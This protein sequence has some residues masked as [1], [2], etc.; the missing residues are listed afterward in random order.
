MS[1]FDVIIGYNSIKQELLMC[2]DSMKNIEKYKKLGV[3]P[4]R[5]IMLCGEPGV[6]KTLMAECFLKEC[7]CNTY[8]IRK[9][10][11]KDELIKQILYIFREAKKNAPS[12]IMLDDM[13]KFTDSESDH[14]CSQEYAAIQAGFEAC[15]NENVMV[16]AT[17]NQDFGIPRSLKRQGRFDRKIEMEFPSGDDAKLILEFFLSKKKVSKDVDLDKLSFLLSGC[18]CASLEMI[19]NDAG[20]YAA[21]EGK[22]VIEDSDLENACIRYLTSETCEAEPCTGEK[23]KV[24]AIHEAG[25]AVVSEFWRP[26]SVKAVS[27][28]GGSFYGGGTTATDRQ[29]CTLTENDVIAD[30]SVKLGGKAASSV[31]LDIVDVG[32]HTDVRRAYDIADTFVS[33]ICGD[34]F[35]SFDFRHDN[36]SNY[37]LDNRDQHIE[38]LLDEVY[39]V[40]LDIIR[41]NAKLVKVIADKLVKKNVLTYKELEQVIDKVGWN[42]SKR[43]P[44]QMPQPNLHASKSHKR[45][46]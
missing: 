12:V 39:D 21:Y 26:N 8:T 14:G 16:I 1:A 46:G 27:I 33:G 28:K 22:D 5:G 13:D 40:T 18:T 2:C 23:A 9:N 6:G 11:P 24:I 34:G 42:S 29:E 38:E 15:K 10:R 35:D 7:R 37:C 19:V 17:V 41:D 20:I 32:C 44:Q 25:H 4:P 3:K 43:V 36:N 31:L 30:I 45:K